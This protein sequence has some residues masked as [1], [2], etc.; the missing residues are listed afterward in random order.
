MTRSLPIRVRPLPEEALDSWLAANAQRMQCTWGEILDAVLPESP[1]TES[2]SHD[3]GM[4]WGAL[5]E[6]ER[7]SVSDANEVSPARLDAMTLA[8]R[9]GDQIITIHRSTRNV[10][11]PWGRVHRQRFCPACLRATNGRFNLEWR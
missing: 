7:A 10:S 4:L 9:F 5:T 2:V 1:D 8:G 11:T 3:I 6:R